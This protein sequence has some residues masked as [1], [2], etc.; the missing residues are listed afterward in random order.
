MNTDFNHNYYQEH[1][2][3]MWTHCPQKRGG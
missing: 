2:S 3:C 1:M